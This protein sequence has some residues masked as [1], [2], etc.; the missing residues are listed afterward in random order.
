MASGYFG[1]WHRQYFGVKNSKG[2][3]TFFSKGVRKLEGRSL[4]LVNSKI[5]KRL[6]TNLGDLPINAIGTSEEVLAQSH[7]D[8]RDPVL[9]L[10]HRI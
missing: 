6:Q 10:C 4:L 3:F 1:V 9:W 7:D 2:K 8:I 5:C